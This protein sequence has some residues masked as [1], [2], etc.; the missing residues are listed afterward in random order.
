MIRNHSRNMKVIKRMVI[1]VAVIFLLILMW[2][3]YV[4]W[5]INSVHSSDASQPAEVGI[6]LGSSMWG[7]V[8]SP[9]LK[10]RLD[11][12]L[13]QYNE[14]KFDWFIVSGGLDQPEFNFTEAEGMRQYLLDHGVSDKVIMMEN[15]ATSTLENLQFSQHIMNQ[16]GWS[17]AIIITHTYHGMRS[18]EMAEYLDYAHPLLSTTDSKV[19]S[20]SYHKSREI[21]AYSK[22]KL[23][24]C[25]LRLGFKSLESVNNPN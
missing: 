10:E 25:L 15:E 16:H 13:K 6:I 2:S 19:L 18:L 4:V 1:T 22:W 21:L 7:D 24:E 12:G 11:H 17:S 23:D 5:K 9:S 3:G 20:M 8:P 14:G